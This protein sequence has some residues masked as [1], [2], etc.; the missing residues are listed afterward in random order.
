[1]SPSSRVFFSFAKTR[2]GCVHTPVITRPLRS[3]LGALKTVS[4]RLWPS[5]PEKGPSHLL[6]CPLLSR[7]RL[8][9]YSQAGMLGVRYHPRQ[10]WGEKKTGLTKF[11]SPIDR[12]RSRS[13]HPNRAFSGTRLSAS[14]LAGSQTFGHT[15]LGACCRTSRLP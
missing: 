13:R 14:Q 10:H 8:A 12:V 3:E 7:K 6:C 1:M 15:G 9:D 4:A 2:D 11:E 5:L